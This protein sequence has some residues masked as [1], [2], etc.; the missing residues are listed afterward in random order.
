MGAGMCPPPRERVSNQRRVL[1]VVGSNR[2]LFATNSEQITI[3][4]THHGD[5]N[6]AIAV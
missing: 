2:V 5:F 3:L 1:G 4:C 6:L